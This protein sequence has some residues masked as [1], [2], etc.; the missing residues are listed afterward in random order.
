MTRHARFLQATDGV[1]SGRPVRAFLLALAVT[2]ASGVALAAWS[3]NDVF[4][5]APGPMLPRGTQLDRLLDEAQVSPTQR[6]QAH[7]IFDAA[8]LEL[9][10][11]RG[12][13]RADR[14]QLAR[15]FAQPTVDAAAIE[16]VRSRIQQ[17][18][19]TQ[20]RRATQAL[21]DVGL[22]LTPQ[23]RQV[24]ASQLAGGPRPFGASFHAHAASAVQ[25]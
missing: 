16:T 6:A 23:Q 22:V 13:D 19:D 18:H 12:A 8:D 5:P 11:G 4:E 9:T 3:A 21:I 10:Q 7:Q 14:A 24:V 20:S 25:D 2:L 1:P 15:L 17:R